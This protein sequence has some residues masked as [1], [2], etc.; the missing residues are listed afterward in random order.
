MSCSAVPDY[1]GSRICE[2]GKT[3][4]ASVVD[5]RKKRMEKKRN[6]REERNGGK[7]DDGMTPAGKVDL[8]A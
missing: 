5:K 1:E 7:K 8:K 2:I 3:I 6:L 4:H